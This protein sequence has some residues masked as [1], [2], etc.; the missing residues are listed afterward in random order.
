MSFVTPIQL[1]AVTVRALVTEN[2]IH[3]EEIAVLPKVKK[4]IQNWKMCE[5]IEIQ[6]GPINFNWDSGN[7]S[8]SC[9][10]KQGNF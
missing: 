3:W 1:A 2:C 9:L 6:K 8:Q 4:K 5:V 7:G 10:G